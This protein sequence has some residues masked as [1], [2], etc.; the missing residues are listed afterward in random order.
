MPIDPVR[1]IRERLGRIPLDAIQ[2]RHAP[3]AYKFC[4]PGAN[5]IDRWRE[6]RTLTDETGYWPVILGDDKDAGRVLQYADSEAGANHQELLSHAASQTAQQWLDAR[7][8]AQ[9]QAVVRLR[10]ILE[11]KYDSARVDEILRGLANERASV[12]GSSDDEW[13]ETSHSLTQFT[14]PFERVGNGPP[15]EKVA[16]GLFPTKN[17]WEIPAHLNLGG[18]NECPDAVGHVVMMKAWADEYGAELIGTNGDTIEMYA[19]S[20]PSSREDSFRLAQQQYLYC[21]D[22]VSQGTQSVIALAAG[23][24]GNNIW[25]FWWD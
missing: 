21:E 8:A 3:Q 12:A 14:I 23:L 6:F 19:T 15:K 11:K 25:Y 22:I 5:A 9:G 18:W 24:L 20:P 17:G 4:C 16:I 13:P 1:V 10:V 7:I 2:N